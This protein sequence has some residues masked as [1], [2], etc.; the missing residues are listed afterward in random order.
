MAVLDLLDIVE[1]HREKLY[2]FIHSRVP[3]E[4]D[5]WDILQDVFT[6]LTARWNL[7]E[8]LEDGAAWLFKVAR[9]KIV[10]LYRRRSRSEIS[11]EAILGSDGDGFTA[12]LKDPNGTDPGE[13]NGRSDLRGILLQVIR[14]LPPEQR[15]IFKQTELEGRKFREIA[16]ESGVPMGTLLTRKRYAV[17]KLHKAIRSYESEGKGD[18]L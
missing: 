7:G 15:D 4:E 11:L 17:L 13:Y 16:L 5:S 1:E 10:D 2:A 12:E 14:D 8:T 9:N 3:G 18:E 6:T